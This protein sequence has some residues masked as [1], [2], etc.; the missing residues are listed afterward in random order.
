MWLGA[1]VPRCHFSLSYNCNESSGKSGRME[2]L[3]DVQFWFNFNKMTAKVQSSI[4]VSSLFA[5]ALL[6]MMNFR[7]CLLL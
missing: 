3:E 5:D 2:S 1:G 4:L 6:G 7:H